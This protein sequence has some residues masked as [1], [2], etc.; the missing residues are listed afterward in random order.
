MGCIVTVEVSNVRPFKRA[1]LCVTQWGGRG[2][3]GRQ[4][5]WHLPPPEIPNGAPLHQVGEALELFVIWKFKKSRIQKSS[6]V[7]ADGLTERSSFSGQRPLPSSF[8]NQ[9]WL[10]LFVLG[11]IRQQLSHLQPLLLREWNKL[12]VCR[13]SALMKTFWCGSLVCADPEPG[14]VLGAGRPV[15]GWY[16]GCDHERK[17]AAEHYRRQHRTGD[18]LTVQASLI[19]WIVRSSSATCLSHIYLLQTEAFLFL[20]CRRVSDL[21]SCFFNVLARLAKQQLKLEVPIITESSSSQQ[22]AGSHCTLPHVRM[23]SPVTP[24]DLTHLSQLVRLKEP[25][26]QDNSGVKQCFTEC[27]CVRRTTVTAWTWR[28]G[29][30]WT[31]RPPERWRWRS[32]EAFS[33]PLCSPWVPLVCRFHKARQSSGNRKSIKFPTNQK[34]ARF[35]ET[36]I[37][38]NHRWR[39]LPV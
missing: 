25:V 33:S 37:R 32:Q 31:S 7:S 13:T 18:A 10:L 5:Q 34:Q 28:C 6:R 29:A 4:H 39:S 23:S 9:S 21:L 19:H 36:Q 20:S 24:E 26:S 22:A 8:C 27:V 30:N 38:R 3:P 14:P 35:S 2:L 16:L 15:Q 1:H 11:P 12:H 17:P